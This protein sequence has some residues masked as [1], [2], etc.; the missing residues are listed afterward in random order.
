MRNSRGSFLLIQL[1]CPWFFSLFDPWNSVVL[2]KK[3]PS[4]ASLHYCINF[5]KSSNF[6]HPRVWRLSHIALF[7]FSLLTS[8]EALKYSSRSIKN[9]VLNIHG[10]RDSGTRMALQGF[11]LPSKGK[12]SL[13]K[14]WVFSE[15]EFLSP[16]GQMGKLLIEQAWVCPVS[17]IV[18]EENVLC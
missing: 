9:L 11:F 16:R 8:I 17:S 7:S 2:K 1:L 13:W 14:N 15:L 18:G 5:C 12:I 4:Q 3:V 10:Y 6:L